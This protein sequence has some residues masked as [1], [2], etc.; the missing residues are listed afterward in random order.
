MTFP[1]WFFPKKVVSPQSGFFSELRAEQILS[2]IEKLEFRISE[3]FPESGLRKVCREFRQLAARL[4]LLAIELGKPIWPVR[5]VTFV[6]GGLLVWVAW[7]AA[8][9]LL[10]KF[11]ASNEAGS[12]A[13]LLQASEAAINEFIFLALALFFLWSLETRL[14]RQAALKALHQLRSIAHIVDMHQLTKDPAHVLSSAP[15]TLRETAASPERTFTTFELSRYLDYCSELLAL[16]AKIS[17]LFAQTMDD[18][19][20]LTAVNELESLAQGLSGKIWQKI[21]I[22]DLAVDNHA[23]SSRH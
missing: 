9:L 11:Y 6:A 2:T 17:A 1:D 7:G 3:R 19:V 4:E 13:E 20:V 18:P 15:P 10:Q 22:L 21:M 12:F 23:P 8:S 14:K 16:I 5:L